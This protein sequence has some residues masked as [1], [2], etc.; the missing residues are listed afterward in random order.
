MSK[1]MYGVDAFLLDCDH[2][3]K[4]PKHRIHIDD[5]VKCPTCAEIAEAVEKERERIFK[6]VEPALLSAYETLEAEA[7]M[8]NEQDLFT[9]V[10]RVTAV[11]DQVEGS[12]K[13]LEAKQV[14][15]KVKDE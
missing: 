2:R 14:E 4:Q 12:L 6:I 11:L 9:E 1:F 13:A 15:V 7:S 8:W 3:I 10:D 5:E